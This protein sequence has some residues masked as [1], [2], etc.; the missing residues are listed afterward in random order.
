MSKLRLS[1]TSFDPRVVYDGHPTLFT[2]KLH[3]R[4]EF[5]KFPGVN[6][7]EGTVTYDDMMDIEEFSIHEMDVIM[8]SEVALALS[9]SPEYNKKKD[10]IK[11][12]PLSSC[13]K[14]L[15]MDDVV[16]VEVNE[17]NVDNEVHEGEEN[18]IN[19]VH[20]GEDNAENREMNEINDENV[21]MR[22]F[23]VDDGIK[24]YAVA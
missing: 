23:A 15:A 19:E 20:A 2:I 11:D 14:K 6:Y 16:N 4:G 22:D 24:E 17:Q 9:I 7:I 5:I 1:S 13:I 18:A 21:E 3:H 8:K 12:K 10:F